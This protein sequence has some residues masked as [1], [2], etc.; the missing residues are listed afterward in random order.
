MQTKVKSFGK[1]ISLVAVAFAVL[2]LGVAG[3]SFGFLIG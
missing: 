3:F 1:F 2:V